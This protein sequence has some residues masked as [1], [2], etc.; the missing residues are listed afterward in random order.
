MPLLTSLKKVDDSFKWL[1]E[2]AAAALSW[3]ADQPAKSA[4][5]CASI[6]ENLFS[7]APCDQ[8]A[9]FMCESEEP[10]G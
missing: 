5:D 6:L 8:P 10:E 7:A 2:S 9:S 3:A 4:G 1:G